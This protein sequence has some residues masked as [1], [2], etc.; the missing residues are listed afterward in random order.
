MAL[1]HFQ[2]LNLTLPQ[3][4]ATPAASACHAAFEAWCAHQQQ[5]GRLRH[6]TSVKVYRAMWTA[7]DA[8][9][10][11][12]PGQPALQALNS[13]LL[14]RY[15]DSRSGIAGPGQA[16]TVRYRLRLLGLVRR[17]QAF[18]LSR[19]DQLGAAAMPGNA[20]RPGRTAAALAWSEASL[21]ARPGNATTL[22]D[23]P[24]NISTALTGRLMDWLL[25]EA[26]A[27]SPAR[28]QGL[29]DRCA[30]ALQLG[31]GIGP[32]DLRALRLAEVRA[33]VATS[34]EQAKHAK[35]AKQAEHAGPPATV[36][37]PALQH[38]PGWHLCVPANG[39]AR[40]YQA[41]VAAWAAGLL[42]QWLA[43]RAQSGLQGEWLFPSTR[44]GKPWGKVAQYS[45][46][47]KALAD[48]GLP[49]GPGGSFRLRHTFA[50]RQLQ[51]GHAA[52]TVAS[53]LGVSDPNVMQRYQQALGAGLIDPATHG[54]QAMAMA[55]DSSV[56]LAPWPV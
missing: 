42:Q 56:A 53:W 8:W 39:N 30:L 46:V 7:L 48:A 14:R 35:H 44:S 22:A 2:S 1:V 43:C 54:A 17:V 37:D 12:Q 24:G 33:P 10:S 28:W 15:L 49:D 40:A 6:Q 41:P 55:P 36:P 5:I 32:G 51:H 9:C 50:L 3:A 31:A 47:R 45:S 13:P 18:D 23:A 38:S 29:R 26:R 52:D 19:H 25:D 27:A 21:A 16:L 34:A 11:Q 4:P 20:V